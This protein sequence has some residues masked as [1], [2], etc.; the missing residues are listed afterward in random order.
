MS[1]DDNNP[2]YACP[3]RGRTAARHDPVLHARAAPPLVV[4][5][6]SPWADALL[7]L[8]TLGR[9]RSVIRSV[10]LGSRLDGGRCNLF[11]S[12]LRCE[13]CPVSCF[14]LCSLLVLC[15]LLGFAVPLCALPAHPLPGAFYVP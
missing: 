11:A 3:A 10:R 8:P 9:E 1:G 7:G 12:C 4:E 14:L 13:P 2:C 15:S 5:R 6:V